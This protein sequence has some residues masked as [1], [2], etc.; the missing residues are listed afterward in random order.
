MADLQR[1][2]E[3]P[4]RVLRRFRDAVLQSLDAPALQAAIQARPWDVGVSDALDGERRPDPL[5]D[6]SQDE[7][8]TALRQYRPALAD[9]D[10]QKSACRAACRPMSAPLLPE[11]CKWGAVQSVA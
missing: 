9:G 1:L 4:C 2:A 11:L 5:P 3:V 8:R 10:A 6:Q 7:N